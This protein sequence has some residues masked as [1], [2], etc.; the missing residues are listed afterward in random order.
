MPDLDE[1][2]RTLYTE[3]YK[4]GR[5]FKAEEFVAATTRLAG[6]DYSNF[7]RR[8]VT[9]TDVPPYD[10]PRIRAACRRDGQPQFILR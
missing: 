10:E 1:L 7:F 5:G 8:F 4:R 3:F 9:G 6:H 2:M